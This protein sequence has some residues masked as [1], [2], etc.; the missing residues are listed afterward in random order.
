MRSLLL[1]LALT[2][3]A[4]GLYALSYPSFLGDGWFPLLFIA[5][6]FFLWRLEVAPNLKSSLLH[7]LA[8][9]LG[10]NLV[11]YYW[12]PHTLR[13]FG[14]L[15]WIISIIL[16]MLFTL[17]LQ[18]HWYLYIIWKEFRPRFKWGTETGSIITAFLMMFLE[19]FTTQQ[20][21]SYVGSPWLHLAPYLSL[22]PYFGVAVFSFMTYWLSIEIYTQL[23]IK[24]FRPFVWIAMLIFVVVNALSPLE[25][26]EGEDLNVRIVQAN[27]GNFLK[28]DSE[29]GGEE[30]GQSIN[31]IYLRLS[32]SNKNFSPDLIIWPE[33]AYPNSFEEKQ[34]YL[35]PLFNRIMEETKAEMLIG[36]YVQDSTK[37]PFTLIESV[38]NAS[39]LMSE[40][41]VKSS[42]HKN[43]LIPF[44]ETLPFGP[45]NEKIVEIVPAVSLFGRGEGTP[46]METNKGMRFVTPICYEVLDT[47]FVRALLNQWGENKF[48]VNHTNDSWYG[49][50]AEPFQHLFL[51]KWR[52]LEFNLPLIR[53]TNTG[54][55]SVIYPDGSESERLGINQIGTLDLKLKVSEGN[56]TFYQKNGLYPLVILLSILGIILS[57]KDGL[58]TSKKN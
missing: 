44:G 22:A 2:F 29:R 3:G 36:G 27:I 43:I 39:V 20:F 19:R 31:E 57:L 42:Y 11:G 46:L 5:V 34:E 58:F 38:F 33:T 56:S 16:G 23:E 15:P 55:T 26:N 8:Y 32:A 21:P 53:S 54:I 17:I 48:I 50:T 40:G 10:L 28:L 14:N 12:I 24:K 18:P 37:S 13:E 9:N 25:K 1:S 47:N 41:K 6:P 35:S 45:L 30:S 7:V 4:G 51:S 52:A 49:D